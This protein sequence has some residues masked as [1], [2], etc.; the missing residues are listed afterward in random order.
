MKSPSDF[1]SMNFGAAFDAMNPAKF[2]ESMQSLQQSWSGF[3]S[4][5]ALAPTMDLDEIDKRITDLK[6]VEQWLNLNLTMLQSTVQALQVQRATVATLQNLNESV[7]SAVQGLDPEAITRAMAEAANSGPAA[8]MG[9]AA[10]PGDKPSGAGQNDDAPAAD[11]AQWWNLL[12]N[13]FDMLTASTLAAA[14][15]AN[16]A[17]GTS[18]RPTPAPPKQKA[19]PKKSSKRSSTAAAARGSRAGAAKP[20]RSPKG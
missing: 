11:P 12:R 13:Q 7:N 9:A 18:N 10:R 5:A 2:M 8:A 15:A 19:N 20:K 17:A 1:S 16:A 3:S 14:N 4:P 6:A